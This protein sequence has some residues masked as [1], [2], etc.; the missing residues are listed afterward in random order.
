MAKEKEQKEAN[1]SGKDP[2]D[3]ETTYTLTEEEM[4]K[5]QSETK[6]LKDLYDNE[7]RINKEIQK[8][9][10]ELSAKTI[11]LQSLLNDANKENNED[12]EAM[13]LEIHE[14]ETD[15]AVLIARIEETLV[16]VDDLNTII[17]KLIDA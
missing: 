15:N 7:V 6:D 4:F 9:H 5:I 16:R 3:V 10:K 1:V 17:S 13:N 14:L 12:I 11:E 8:E 2:K